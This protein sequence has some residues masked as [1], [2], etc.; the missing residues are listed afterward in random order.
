MP[1]S[2]APRLSP[3]D[4]RLSPGPQGIHSARRG[5]LPP[6][7]PARRRAARRFGPHRPRRPASLLAAPVLLL[8]GAVCPALQPPPKAAPSPPP[9]VG[10]ALERYYRGDIEKSVLAFESILA[11]DPRN[12]GVRRQLVELY[13]EMGD[14]GRAVD[15]L[16]ESWRLAEEGGPAIERQLF[17]SLCLGGR[18]DQ[19]AAILPLS[20]ENG[21]TLF[22]EALLARDMGD[23]A[24]AAA[25]L[26]KS[27]RQE[28]RRP[29]AWHFLGLVLQN[30]A[31][32][33]AEA[34]FRMALKQDP[35]LTAALAPLAE[36][37]LAQ[38]RTE[39]AYRLFLRAQASQPPLPG[40]AERIGEVK[41]L[42][43]ETE[44]R[45][46]EAAV[47]KRAAATPPRAEPAGPEDAAPLVRVGL[48]EGLGSVT[49]KTGADYLLT[50][51]VP[52]EKEPSHRG[53]RHEVLRIVS[54]DGGLEVVR[55][56]G[57]SILTSPA[58]LVLEYRDPGAT[59]LVFDFVSEAGSFFSVTEDRAYRGRLEFRP[60]PGG[61]TLINSLGIE[62]YL[63]G[64]L[65]SEMPAGWPREALKAQAVAA[66]SYTL[67]Y[68]GTYAS[69]GFDL[70]GS[71][72]SAAYRGVGGESRST[73]EAV[74][75][76]RGLYMTVGGRPLRAYYSANHGGYS[77]DSLFVWGADADMQAVPDKLVAPR[78]SFLPIDDLDLWV[79]GIPSSYSS[80][81]RLHSPAAYRWEKWVAADEIARRLAPETQVGTIVRILTRGRGISGRVNAVEVV[82]TAGSVTVTGDRIRSRL[83]GLRSNLFVLRP[84]LGPGG[85]PEYVVFHGAGWGHGVG[86]DQSGAAGMAQAGYG[87]E[88]ILRHYYPKAEKADYRDLYR[89]KDR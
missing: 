87:A 75:A 10:E 6:S 48:A 21:E 34:A 67:A 1:A 60:S 50:P 70:H 45:G 17:I 38:G 53:S 66:R 52:G 19:A 20:S 31:P 59:T 37:V 69:R 79:R 85:F 73:T 78:D 63:Y 5:S 71:V 40:L 82:G 35:S 46:K 42:L 23:P 68:L 43:P 65:P 88:E 13:R 9:T 8:L 74:D 16:G 18:T 89:E 41:A 7:R 72:L 47:R 51:S 39:E 64:V 83:G 4:S 3:S 32:A 61:L 29:A 81:D 56:S 57:E 44:T 12:G 2:P 28:E 62:E 55:E 27:L 77:E 76:T 24:K 84:K 58:S 15:L 49:V 22:H 26:R 30:A 33:E 36:T 86:M 25:L 80:V 14:Y 54:R 11:S